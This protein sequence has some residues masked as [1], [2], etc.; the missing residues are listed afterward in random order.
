MRGP[1]TV[2]IVG[3]GR[4]RGTRWAIAQGAISGRCAD[5]QAERR[6]ERAHMAFRVL[7]GDLIG[8][9][10]FD[11]W[12]H[13]S[14]FRI[15]HLPFCASPGGQ[16]RP[17]PETSSRHCGLPRSIQSW[18][19]YHAGHKPTPAYGVSTSGVYGGG[20]GAWVDESRP[21]RPQG[22]AR[23]AARW[24][25]SEHCSGSPASRPAGIDPT[26]TG[27]RVR[28]PDCRWIGSSV[29]LRFWPRRMM[30]VSMH[31]IWRGLPLPH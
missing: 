26:R 7:R 16:T 15:A 1:K 19:C 8:P 20:D 21:L 11:H 25:P 22:S 13:L 5:S 9:K 10:V 12:H 18:R 3:F 30:F 29:V 31:K 23:Q 24:T 14:P 27:Y 17:T 2:L 6:E 28:N 4:H